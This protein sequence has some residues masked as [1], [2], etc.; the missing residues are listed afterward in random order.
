MEYYNRSSELGNSNSLYALGFMWGTG[1]GVPVNIP[2]V[3]LSQ[4]KDSF[5]FF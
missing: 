3:M 1:K 5:F 2:L 4:K